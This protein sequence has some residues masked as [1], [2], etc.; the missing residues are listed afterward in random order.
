MSI[1]EVKDKVK[2]N[3]RHFFS[4]DL[5]SGYYQ[6]G[7]QEKSK[8]LTTFIVPQGRVCFNVLPTAMKPSLDYF[9]PTTKCLEKGN[10]VTM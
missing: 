7:L 3:W 4:K 9:N 10:T 6:D 8:D 1:Y 5:T 2:P